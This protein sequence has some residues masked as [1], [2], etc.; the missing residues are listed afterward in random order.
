MVTRFTGASGSVYYHFDLVSIVRLYTRDENEKREAEEKKRREA[1]QAAAKEAEERAA[2]NAEIAI[3][4]LVFYFAYLVPILVAGVGFI[5]HSLTTGESVP[6]KW[7]MIVFLVPV[8]NWL[9]LVIFMVASDV[10]DL[11]FIL[12]VVFL[13]L[14]A[15]LWL[16]T[17]KDRFN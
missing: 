6:L 16:A 3:V 9:F 10:T 1:E 4:F 15:V 7:D 17:V 14:G 5:W 8:I 11:I 13:A 2:R 12:T